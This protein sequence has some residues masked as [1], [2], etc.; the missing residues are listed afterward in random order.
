M[1]TGYT[2]NIENGES[3]ENF[4]LGCARAFGACAHQRDDTM[5]DK[6]KLREVSNY[7]EEKLP[8]ALAELGFLQSLTDTQIDEHGKELRDEEIASIQKSIEEKRALEGKY[9]AM[10]DKVSAWNPPTQ[11]HVGLKEFMIKQ[12]KDTIDF[13]CNTKYYIERLQTAISKN[14]IDFYNDALQSAEWNVNHYEEELEK[15]KTRVAE[16]NN[17][18]IELYKSLG[19]SLT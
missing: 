17:W 11:D 10:L 4:V 19:I 6:P 8:E 12:I 14:A 1:P 18:I 16:S 7:Y 5:K 9:M 15:E 2:A 13:D 3:F